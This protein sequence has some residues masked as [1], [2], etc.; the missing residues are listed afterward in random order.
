[1]T[2]SEG[3]PTLKIGSKFAKTTKLFKKSCF[4]VV[5]C[6]TYSFLEGDEK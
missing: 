5:V 3:N 4:L 6:V 1:M 2:V